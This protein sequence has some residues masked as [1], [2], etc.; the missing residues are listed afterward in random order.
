MAFAA[1][2]GALIVLGEFSQVL[3]SRT[4]R[5]LHHLATMNETLRQLKHRVAAVEHRSAVVAERA[6]SEDA[7]KRI[8]SAPDLGIIKLSE[9]ET[10][11]KRR[12]SGPLP[13]GTLV[14][15][16]SQS[17]AILQVAKIAPAAKDSVYRVW[18]QKKRMPETLAAEF[19]PDADGSATVPMPLPP[20]DATMI[21]VTRES[22]TDT[23]RPS[24]PVIL[25]GR[26]TAD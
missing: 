23:S 14:Y 21:Q 12:T 7:L 11:K 13:S 8:V 10:A 3:V 26:M 2:L 20:Q 5:Y 25:K 18:W 16:A 15:S 19:T 24:G 9:P 1:A 4:N 17:L 22:G 6:S